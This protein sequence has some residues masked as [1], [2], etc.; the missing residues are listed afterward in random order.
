MSNY[1]FW[2]E[3]GTELMTLC[4]DHTKRYILDLMGDTQFDPQSN[5]DLDSISGTQ[6][7]N[8]CMFCEEQLNTLDYKV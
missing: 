6:T 4:Q 3:T 2:D 1:Q 5:K 8:P 7:V